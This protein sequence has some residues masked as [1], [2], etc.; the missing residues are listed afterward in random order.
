[1]FIVKITKVIDDQVICNEGEFSAFLSR[2]RI[3][4]FVLCFDPR[5]HIRR[6]TGK[7]FQTLNWTQATTQRVHE[8]SRHEIGVSL[9]TVKMIDF[10]FQDKLAPFRPFL[11]LFIVLAR[12]VCGIPSCYW[13][14]NYR[15]GAWR[16]GGSASMWDCWPY[17]TNGRKSLEKCRFAQNWINIKWKCLSQMRPFHYI[18]KDNLTDCNL[19]LHWIYSVN[20]FKEIAWTPNVQRRRRPCRRQSAMCTWGSFST[21]ASL[22][23]SF[24]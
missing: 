18:P 7:D 10:T 17:R 20:A 24:D 4:V 2:V 5:A 11:P 6:E 21:E 22:N 12:M 16:S 9:W 14:I 8:W 19:Q 15:H 1:M 13:S 3:L 23:G